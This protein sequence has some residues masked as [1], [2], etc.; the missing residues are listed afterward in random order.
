FLG[1]MRGTVWVNV[2]QCCMF[3]LFG[4]VAMI[5]ISAALPGGFADDIQKLAANDKT[6]FLLTREKMSPQYF[7][8]Y[9]LIPLSSI[10]F[11]HMA[12]M[13]FSARRVT[14]FKGAVILYPLAIL[15]IWLPCVFLGVI[16]KQA[17]PALK[18]TEADG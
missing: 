4:A 3:L 10:M 2:L 1:G 18:P 14:A 9:T 15:A 6:H 17:L 11:P 7:W 13:C 16:G 5:V 8:S 12:I